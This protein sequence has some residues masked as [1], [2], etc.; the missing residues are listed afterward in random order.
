MPSPSGWSPASYTDFSYLGDNNARA[1]LSGY[2][3]G[4]SVGTGVTLTYSFPW[5]GGS[6]ASWDAGSYT[7]NDPT[8][9]TNQIA[10]EP[11]R[12]FH[13]GLDATQQG[14]AAS[15][16]SK[17][18]DVANVHFALTSDDQFEVGDLR[19]AFTTT[20]GSE[21]GHGSYPFHR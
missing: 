2:K 18:A 15:A 10:N 14:Y 13:F 21:G 12:E 9:L 3:W 16:L 11:Y 17:W 19:I 8:N 20:S 7:S 5:A 6:N 4:G 1:L